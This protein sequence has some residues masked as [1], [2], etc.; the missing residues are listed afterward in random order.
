[1]K[2][3]WPL[4]LPLFLFKFI[5]HW[6]G[7]QNYGFH[8]DE[9]L[10][11]AASE[12][13]DWGYFEFPPMIAFIGKLSGIFFD[14]SLVGTRFFSTLSGLLILWLCIAMAKEMGGKKMAMFLA[15]ISA[16]TF[17]PFYRNHTLF[18]PVA[19]DQLFWTAGFYFM[20]RILKSD[21]KK[22]YLFLGIVAGLGLLT[23]YT[24]LVWGF[25]IA[26]SLFAFDRSIFRSKWIFISGIIALIIFLPN[27]IW[28]I[29]HDFPLIS[30]MKELNEV[31]LSKLSIW[32]FPKEQLSPILTVP[33][34][35]AGLVGFIFARP[36]QKYRSVGLA[37]MVI[38]TTMWIL[39]AKA[40]YFFAA[41]PVIFAAGAVTIEE[42][43]TKR[44]WIP[45]SI[46]GILFLLALPVIPQMTPILPIETYTDW[47][48]IPSEN[49][50]YE[51]S[52][53]YAD[54]FG[55]DEQVALVDS[56]FRSLPDSIQANTVIWAENYGEAGAVQILGK[57]YELPVPFSRHGSFWA[58]GYGN[59][60]ASKWISLGNEAES[61][62]YAFQNC[63]LV[64]Q[65]HHPYA[66]EEENDIPL[67][68][69]DTPNVNIP[70][71]WASYEP[72]I[73]D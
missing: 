51:L 55:W 23:K 3:Y 8:R 40:Y 4:L 56:V 35:L 34:T 28:Q 43:F 19:F 41:Y 17:L 68:I 16:L 10:H 52:G 13:L 48:E 6:F 67:Y 63:E 30:H 32:D 45:Y 7:N 31:Q 39:K 2:K 42:W 14:Y 38:F 5:I 73:F 37:F 27:L 15:G 36:L 47:Y 11:L 54:M 44:R 24:M 50:R 46:A 20:I 66:I 65:I 1:M 9:L 70:E 25:G 72:Y 22:E 33:I 49:G 69:C 18:Q 59:S 58:W 61:V 26:I 21:Q 57:K 60:D 71:W 64:K 12:Y 62:N 53:D 29:T